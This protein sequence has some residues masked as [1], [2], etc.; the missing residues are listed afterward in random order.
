M[1]KQD[2]FVSYNDTYKI[3]ENYPRACF[4]VLDEAGHSL[5]IEKIK[6]LEIHTLDWLERIQR[7]KKK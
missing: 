3:L 2:H 1:G 5:E 6:I 7:N 4:C